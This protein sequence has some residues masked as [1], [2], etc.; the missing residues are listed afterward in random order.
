MCNI[1]KN[2]SKTN[3]WL[4]KIQPILDELDIN[5]VQLGEL[6]NESVGSKLN[7]KPLNQ[8]KLKKKHIKINDKNIHVIRKAPCSCDV[9]YTFKLPFYPND[10]EIGSINIDIRRSGS[11]KINCGL[12]NS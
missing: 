8:S 10:I 5:L 7:N 12:N 6:K 11:N 3:T 4:N 9:N 1:L 2:R